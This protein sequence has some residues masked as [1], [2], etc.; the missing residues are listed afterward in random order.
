MLDW[1]PLSFIKLKKVYY[2]TIIK[3][4]EEPNYFNELQPFI[5]K[6]SAAKN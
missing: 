6:I 1:Q 5:N 3:A 4:I 2:L